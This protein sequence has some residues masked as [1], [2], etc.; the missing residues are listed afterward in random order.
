M[1]SFGTSSIRNSP[2]F[3]MLVALPSL[4][5]VDFF[6]YF[7]HIYGQL[8]ENYRNNDLDVLVN[9][10]RIYQSLQSIDIELHVLNQISH[11]SVIPIGSCPEII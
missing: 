9:V 11:F 7:S 10:A 6:L 2:S 5:D 1:N 8:Y 4:A 3:C